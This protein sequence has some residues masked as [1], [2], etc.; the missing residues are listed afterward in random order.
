MHRKGYLLF[1]GLFL[2]IL[3]PR[4]EERA[5][6]CLPPPPPQKKNTTTTTNKQTRTIF[7]VYAA[8]DITPIDT[9]DFIISYNNK[10]ESCPILSQ[11]YTLE[12]YLVETKQNFT[13]MSM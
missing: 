13:N 8:Q 6:L 1:L 2:R 9:T 7:F 4:E 12:I 11:H 5:G 10:P 3:Y